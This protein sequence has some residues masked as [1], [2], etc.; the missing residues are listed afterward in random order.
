MPKCRVSRQA[1]ETCQ[2]KPTTRLYSM[3]PEDKEA[4][5][6][7]TFCLRR[8]LWCEAALLHC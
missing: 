2:P 8:D 6:A 7:S 5:L 1:S 4:I 3:M